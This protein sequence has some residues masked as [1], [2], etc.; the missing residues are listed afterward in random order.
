MSGVPAPPAEPPL[1]NLIQPGDVRF[2]S[3]DSGLAE[4]TACNVALEFFIKRVL[5]CEQ[6]RAPD[7][8]DFNGVSVNEDSVKGTRN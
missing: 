3:S 4:P 8:F 5:R 1:R 7:V 2:Y 6:G